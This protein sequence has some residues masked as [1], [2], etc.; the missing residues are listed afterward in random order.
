MPYGNWLWTFQSFKC[1]FVLGYIN[2]AYKN[3]TKQ[4]RGKE[5]K[6]AL[7]VLEVVGIRKLAFLGSSSSNEQIVSFKEQQMC[8][9]ELF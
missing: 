2:A 1:F 5:M 8:H 4:A 3:R 7:V 9:G 6:E